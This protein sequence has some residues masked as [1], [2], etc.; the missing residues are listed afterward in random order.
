MTFPAEDYLSHLIEAEDIWDIGPD[1]NVD[2][3]IHQMYALQALLAQTSNGGLDQW[4]LNEYGNS[5]QMILNVLSIIGTEEAETIRELME[6]FQ[7][8]I[9]SLLSGDMICDYCD[10]GWRETEDEEECSCNE[11]V[12]ELYL[13]LENRTED[14]LVVAETLQVQLNKL[15]QLVGQTVP[16]VWPTWAE[17]R[18]LVTK[19]N[20]AYRP[21]M[22]TRPSGNIFSVIGAAQRCL[23]E[24]GQRHK[25]PLMYEALDNAPN[26]YSAKL[27]AVLEFVSIL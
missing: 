3:P 12:E 13:D 14:V 22:K 7:P 19:K 17:K 11:L 5:V 6:R 9:E 18:S 27:R 26:T 16:E 1:P 10:S 23:T 21:I 2:T 25:I 8:R 24:A 4:L 20:S 15:A